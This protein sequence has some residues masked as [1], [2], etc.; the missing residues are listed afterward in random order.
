MPRG[1]RRLRLKFRKQFA[2][3]Q[4][5]LP[6]TFISMFVAK[7]RSPRDAALQAG[8]SESIIRKHYLDLKTSAEVEE[9]FGIVPQLQPVPAAETPLC[10]F[11]RQCGRRADRTLPGDTC[12]SPSM[13]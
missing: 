1:F 4:G 8:N 10:R 11:L 2:L 12:V 6:H 5:V 7:F 9:F 13:N 3:S